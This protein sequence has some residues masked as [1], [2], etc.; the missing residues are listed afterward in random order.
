MDGRYRHHTAR[1][2][3]T[4]ASR[5]ACPVSVPAATASQRNMIRHG[6]TCLLRDLLH[7]IAGSTQPRPR[8]AW[9]AC[10]HTVHAEQCSVPVPALDRIARG[11]GAVVRGGDC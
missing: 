4:T 7:A 3:R 2:K 11:I 5:S 8:A 10:I 1:H 9:H 6:V